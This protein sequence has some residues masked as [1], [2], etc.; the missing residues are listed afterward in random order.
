MNNMHSTTKLSYMDMSVFLTTFFGFEVHVYFMEL[1]DRGDDIL[2]EWEK[3][4]E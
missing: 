4:E 1:N 3:V 2:V